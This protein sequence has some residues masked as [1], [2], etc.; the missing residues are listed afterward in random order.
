MKKI[1]FN[2]NISISTANLYDLFIEY[3]DLHILRAPDQSLRVHYRPIKC[4][5]LTIWNS[6]E[7]HRCMMQ[8]EKGVA[9]GSQLAMI[10]LDNEQRK[11]TKINV[12]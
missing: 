10:I 5:Q 12:K 7:Y 2:H 4:N 8:R 6:L 11:Q 1:I 9:S 3:T